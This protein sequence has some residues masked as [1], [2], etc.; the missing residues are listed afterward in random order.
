MIEYAILIVM[1]IFA[2]GFAV[3]VDRAKE[4]AKEKRSAS[5]KGDRT[6]MKSLR[7]KPNS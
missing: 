5:A 4:K 7:G 1:V 3:V 2:I 6:R